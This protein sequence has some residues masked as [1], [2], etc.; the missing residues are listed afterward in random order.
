MFAF[1]HSDTPCSSP[2]LCRAFSSLFQLSGHQ[3]YCFWFSVTSLPVL[4]GSCFWCKSPV[5][6]QCTLPVQHQSVSK[7]LVNRKKHLAAK[8]PNI[9]LMSWQRPRRRM[10]V[11][12]MGSGCKNHSKGPLRHVCLLCIQETQHGGYLTFICFCVVFKAL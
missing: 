10:V 12:Y 4:A 3:L 11:L 8:E 6:T 1:A 7:Q 2:H 9:S 5:K